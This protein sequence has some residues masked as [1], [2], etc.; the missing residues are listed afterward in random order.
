MPTAAPQI[1]YSWDFLK[2]FRLEAVEK[3]HS[4]KSVRGLIEKSQEAI[5]PH[6]LECQNLEVLWENRLEPLC[7]NQAKINWSKF[8]PLRRSREEDWS[9]WLAWLL[10]TSK[11]GIL[12]ET[13][14]AESMNCPTETY[15]SPAVDREIHLDGRRA[16]VVI[17]WGEKRMTHIE[18]KLWDGNFEKTFETAKKLHATAPECIWTDFMLIPSQSLEAWNEVAKNHSQD[19]SVKVMV[20]LWNDVARGLRRCLWQEHESVFWRAWAWVFCSVI[21]KELLGLEKLNYDSSHPKIQLV[22]QW[23]SVLKI[24]PEGKL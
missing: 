23:L 4:W 16:D 21:E 2:K 5:K 13:L 8:R 12:A 7:G 11:T 10:E 19:Q 6:I 1:E 22:L 14:F 24:Y 15:I 20:V 18:V 9:D 3:L 17:S